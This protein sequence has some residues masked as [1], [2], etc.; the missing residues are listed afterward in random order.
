MRKGVI[1]EEIEKILKKDTRGMT[2]QEI[3][4]RIGV[5]RITASIGLAKLEGSG[6]IEVRPIGNCK[7]HYW[8][9]RKLT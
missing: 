7:L 4:E 5:S 8:K 3:S 6:L 2:I 1:K 9:K